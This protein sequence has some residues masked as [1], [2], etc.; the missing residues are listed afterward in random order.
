[1]ALRCYGFNCG[2][3][4]LNVYYMEDQWLILIKLKTVKIIKFHHLKM[5]L[6]LFFT[7]V[8][9]FD[10]EHKFTSAS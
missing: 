1:M 8:T 6:L 4:D 3:H 10:N 5:R 7:D 2:Y 9:V